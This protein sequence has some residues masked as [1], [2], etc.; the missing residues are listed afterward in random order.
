MTMANE[1][2][3]MHGPSDGAPAVTSLYARCK[4]CGTQWQVWGDPPT[5]TEGC[6]FCDAPAEAIT[7]LS[8]RQ[9]FDGL[10]VR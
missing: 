10:V 2:V 5:N 8:E 1:W 6:A 3:R 4:V 9:V 7:V